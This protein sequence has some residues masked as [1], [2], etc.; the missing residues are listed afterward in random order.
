[1]DEVEDLPVH[2][3]EHDSRNGRPGDRKAFLVQ[4]NEKIILFLR[5]NKAEVFVKL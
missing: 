3:D 1:V 4:K 5:A 2:R